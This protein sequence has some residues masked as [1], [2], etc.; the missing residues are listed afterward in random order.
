MPEGLLQTPLSARTCN[1]FMLQQ[2]DANTDPFAHPTTLPGAFTTAN[3]VNGR[4]VHATLS[5]QPRRSSSPAAAMSP[6]EP[7]S[8]EQHD[9][10]SDMA[11]E[12]ARE[13]AAGL[14]TRTH[15]CS[16]PGSSSNSPPPPRMNSGKLPEQPRSRHGV[17]ARRVTTEGPCHSEQR[18]GE[19][20]A[21]VGKRIITISTTTAS[22]GAHTTCRRR[23]AIPLHGDRLQ[24]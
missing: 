16:T 23:V 19:D 24:C 1:R 11:Q 2:P 12:S 7:E 9:E 22:T 21:L 20:T 3:V 5:T 18:A 10:A 4:R 8:P 17:D 14:K 6:G 13:V 15:S